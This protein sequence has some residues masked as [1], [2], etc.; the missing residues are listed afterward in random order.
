MVAKQDG[1]NGISTLRLMDEVVS[2]NKLPPYH[3]SS[4][5]VVIFNINGV[6]FAEPRDSISGAS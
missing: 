2:I 4:S 6:L 5:P 1:L 3:I